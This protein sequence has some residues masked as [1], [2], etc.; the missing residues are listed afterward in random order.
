[1]FDLTWGYLI[2]LSWL[3][4][5]R[6]DAYSFECGGVILL[7]KSSVWLSRQPRIHLYLSTSAICFGC[8]R[9]HNHLPPCRHACR[10]YRI[11]K[12][13]DHPRIVKLYDYFSLD[14]DTLVTP[15][16][17]L[18]HLQHSPVCCY[19]RGGPHYLFIDS[20]IQQILHRS[21]VLRRQWLGLL[22]E[23]AQANVG[24][25][26]T[27]HSHADCECTEIP[28]WNKA[29]HHPLRPQAR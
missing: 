14:T 24:E 12:Q 16:F 13:L 1:M 3:L 27:V 25:G 19:F 15:A 22:L 21:G 20:S 23:T 4:F 28:E 10:E 17:L 11:H 2:S 6:L 5:C 18:M 26:G 8:Q 29:S 7:H 9:Q